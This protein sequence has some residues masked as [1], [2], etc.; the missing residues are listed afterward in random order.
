M[1]LTNPHLQMN[2]TEIRRFSYVS[3]ALLTLSILPMQAQMSNN[4]LKQAAQGLSP[5]Q[6]NQIK[7][8]PRARQQA[9]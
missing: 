3:I 5:Q 8:D 4:Q 9:I 2:W 1:K 7:N 6:L